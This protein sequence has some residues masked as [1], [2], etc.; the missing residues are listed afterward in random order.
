MSNYSRSYRGRGCNVRVPDRLRQRSD[1]RPD[2]AAAL[3]CAFLALTVTAACGEGY[4]TLSVRPEGE[5]VRQVFPGDSVQLIAVLLQNEVHF[6]FAS[7]LREVYDSRAR[8]TEFG[9][10]SADTMVATVS[11]DG[12]VRA[13]R[14]GSTEIRAQTQGVTG[15]F[16]LRAEVA[17]GSS[18]A[19]GIE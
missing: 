15:A 8:P 2:R 18:A 4:K 5:S 14:P 16:P 17:V 12:K 9:W 13:R 3:I 7:S 11:R 1:A 19:R 10:S 6:P